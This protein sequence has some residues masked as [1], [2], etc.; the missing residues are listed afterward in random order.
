MAIKL[1]KR[2]KNGYIYFVVFD[3]VRKKIK[4]WF[5]FR[6]ENELKLIENFL[7][8]LLNSELNELFEE[9]AEYNSIKFRIDLLITYRIGTD[10]DIL[11]FRNS[12]IFNEFYLDIRY[13][14]YVNLID[15]FKQ[16]IDTASI[17]KYFTYI[18]SN[19]TMKFDYENTQKN[20]NIVNSLIG[21]K[22][23]ELNII[24][25][26]LILACEQEFNKAMKRAKRLSELEKK[27]KFLTEIKE[28][29]H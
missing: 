26:F 21:K 29:A 10:N 27:S 1:Q 28:N 25:E 11:S 17:E 13:K 9:S 4:D 18:L 2:E 5:L 16:K 6:K 8:N 15:F 19:A 20:F 3:T 24:K 23:E 7:F 12:K 14:E 22:G